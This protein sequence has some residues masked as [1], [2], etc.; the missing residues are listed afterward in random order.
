[1]PHDAGTPAGPRLAS[2]PSGC[3]AHQAPGPRGGAAP[4]AAPVDEPARLYGQRFQDDPHGLYEEL[5]A[6]H[7]SVAP[8]VLEGGVPAWLVVGYQALLQLVRNPEVFSRDSRNWRDAAEGRV[9][10]DWPL[11]PMVAYMP[12]ML[13]A[14]GIEHQRRGGAVT[15]SLGRFDRRDLQRYVER[16]ADELIDAF[17]AEGEAD[18]L[19]RFAQPLPLLAV[20]HVVG[21][22]DE[23][24]PDLVRAINTMLDGGEDALA[25]QREF[26]GIM[27]RTVANRQE[28]PG[29]DVAS[30]MLAHEAGLSA[31]EVLNDLLV[32]MTA[33]HQTTSNWIGN[34]L[35]LMLTDPRFHASVAVGRQTVADALEQVLWQDPPSQNSAGRWAT[36]D[37]LLDGTPIRAGDFL[38]LGITGANN[39]P[40]VRPRTDGPGASRA[41]LA[42]GSGPHMCPYPAQEIAR[43]VCRTAVETILRRLPDLRLAVPEEE[44][45]WRPTPWM[46][47]LTALPVAFTPQR[48]TPGESA[49]TATAAPSTQSSS[50]P[51]PATS[52]ERESASAPP[53]RSSRWS[54]L[55]RWLRGR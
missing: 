37:T 16:V 48:P 27:G 43:M 9:P 24:G 10:A 51:R 39:D 40:E 23:D 29:P 8:V 50:T 7:G 55:T 33:G 18:L 17:V 11:W 15:D 41:H 47:G 52:T 34:T 13:Y 5:R 45:T 46:R 26:A 19:V 42:W 30:R 4:G 25:A 20:G 36:Q 6:R 22:P 49:W 53:A 2:V 21:V 12:A 54:F 44:L 31:E 35:R 1:M 28:A 38:I 3:P 32:V 14:D